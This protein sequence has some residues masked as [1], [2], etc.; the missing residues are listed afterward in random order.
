[1]LEKGGSWGWYLGTERHA[2]SAAG[3]VCD[4]SLFWAAAFN[5]CELKRS[6]ACATKPQEAG[7]AIAIPVLHNALKITETAAST[8]AARHH[9][10]WFFRQAVDAYRDRVA[11]QKNRIPVRTHATDETADGIAAQ[12]HWQHNG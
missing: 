7:I 10:C 9:D 6:Q 3:M 12:M 4:L 5:F 1:M 8:E 2:I 11:L